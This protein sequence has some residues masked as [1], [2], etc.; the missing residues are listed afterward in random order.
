ME[1][2][3]IRWGPR[4]SYGIYALHVLHDMCDL[5]IVSL[6]VLALDV[7]PSTPAAGWPGLQKAGAWA[8]Y[9]SCTGIVRHT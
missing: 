5:L 9:V 4:K 6:G 1:S 8:A 2:Y 7:T 3:R